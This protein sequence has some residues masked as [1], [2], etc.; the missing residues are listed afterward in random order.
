MGQNT[1]P[2]TAPPLGQRSVGT[3]G[4]SPETAYKPY[5]ANVGVGKD[6]G[7]VGVSTGQSG[8]G[9]VPQGRSS[10]GQQQHSGQGSF[11]PGTRF[12]NSSVGVPPNAPTQQHQQQ[13]QSYPQGAGDANFYYSRQGGHSQAYWQ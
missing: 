11:Y 4:G 13:N 9:Q 2:G 5:V 7:S 6:T 3:S 12:A 8:V 10:G 1:G